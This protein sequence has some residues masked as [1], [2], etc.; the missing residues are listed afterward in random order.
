[1]MH[2]GHPTPYKA[3]EQNGL[4]V[5]DQAWQVSTPPTQEASTVAQPQDV[6]V[7]CE[8]VQQDQTA[9][10]D[11]VQYLMCSRLS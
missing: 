10:L 5:V 1:M 6:P 11:R 4:R 7:T 3:N 9:L 2:Q 8:R